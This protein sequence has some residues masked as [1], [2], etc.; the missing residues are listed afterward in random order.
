MNSTKN[1]NNKKKKFNSN[2][3]KHRQKS[4]SG[5][6][7]EEEFD[8]SKW[9]EQIQDDISDFSLRQLAIPGSHDSG[10]YRMTSAIAAPWTACQSLNILEQLMSG[11]RYFDLRFDYF[12]GN[13]KDEFWIMHH[14]WSSRVSLSEILA[15]V[16]LFL[17]EN[18]KEV[19]ILEAS[20]LPFVN[21]PVVFQQFKK[22]L[23]EKLDKWLIP[24]TT[25]VSDAS[26]ASDDGQMIKASVSG[27]D[28]KLKDLWDRD[29][30]V[31]LSLEG[32]DGG[33]EKVFSN[34]VICSRWFDTADVDY[35]RRCCY[36]E[37]TND[38][39]DGLWILQTVL[40]P[41]RS[42][43]LAVKVLALIVNP[44][45]ERWMKEWGSQVN[46]VIIDFVLS[47]EFASILI[48]ANQNKGKRL[49]MQNEVK[50]T[51]AQTTTEVQACSP[52]EVVE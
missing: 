5:E 45:V 7:D 12:Q 9:M 15:S 29:E 22:R 51:T 17:E 48:R 36:E 32:T 6:R 25:N 33:D 2:N 37:L 50:V 28:K 23:V 4:T 16:C 46:I 41:Q 49:K 13:K 30:R 14:Q 31:L 52:S 10:C 42:K 43:P 20:H 44:H 38:H 27:L 24:C 47:N 35:L 34:S 18:K 3:N 40:S 19:V 26:D 8:T 11:I 21:Q 1:S 39:G